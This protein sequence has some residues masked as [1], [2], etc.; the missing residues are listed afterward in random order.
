METCLNF[1][2]QQKLFNVKSVIIS[3]ITPGNTVLEQKWNGTKMINF[4][5][6]FIQKKKEK[7]LSWGVLVSHVRLWESEQSSLVEAHRSTWSQLRGF[8]WWSNSRFHDYELAL[9]NT[10]GWKRK[11]IP[12]DW[13]DTFKGRE[14][15][16]CAKCG[17]IRQEHR[18]A[19]K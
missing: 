4:L 14:A 18:G 12:G 9:I 16:K 6:S 11:F 13:N 17:S 3:V 2:I 1:L 19:E 5:L 15:R 7:Q 8:L 10:E